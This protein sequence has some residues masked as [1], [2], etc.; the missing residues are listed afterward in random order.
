MNQ[1]ILKKIRSDVREIKKN[2]LCVVSKTK[3][4]QKR[5]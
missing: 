1:G 4:K 3:D 2:V 5:V